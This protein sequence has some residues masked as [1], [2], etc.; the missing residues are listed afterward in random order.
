MMHNSSNF[1][2]YVLLDPRKPGGFSYGKYTF[3][4]EPFYVGKG[5][6][7]RA[8]SHLK[9]AFQQ[10]VIE[11][12]FHDHLCNKIRSIYHTAK[13]LPI[14]IICEK[15]L[16]ETAA[17]VLEMRLIPIIGRIDFAAGPLVNRTNGGEGISNIGPA[18]R[19][20][21]RQRQLG[22]KH[23]VEICKKISASNVGKH[24]GPLH[25]TPE[26][27]TKCG[28]GNRGKHHTI[29]HRKKISD[30]VQKICHTKEFKE[31][32]AKPLYGRD[33]SAETRKKISA[34]NT[35]KIRTVESRKKLS[36]ALRGRI[37]S[38]SHRNKL[39]QSAVEQWKRKKLLAI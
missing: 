16:M 30:G 24:S 31:K 22:K 26:A 34:A 6:G 38:E 32:S 39:S 11:T 35:G 28:S 5:K 13:R 23:P 37:F 21:F 15:N 2:V 10:K 9:K 19:E 18:T 17:F 20:K 8:A 33:V 14:I 25:T 4:H 36:A 29:D 1:Y 12:G 27:R 3:N 7:N